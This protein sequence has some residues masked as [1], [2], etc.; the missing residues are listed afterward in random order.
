M[1]KNVGNR[2]FVKRLG[3]YGQPSQEFW[4]GEGELAM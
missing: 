3:R 4:G 2:A 1:G